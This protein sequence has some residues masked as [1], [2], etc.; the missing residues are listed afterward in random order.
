MRT[1][2]CNSDK[3]DDH[4]QKHGA[5]DTNKANPNSEVCGELTHNRKHSE[6]RSDLICAKVTVADQETIYVIDCGSWW[7][8]M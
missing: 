8:T 7:E 2:I 1:F 4:Q 6:N 5:G 3:S